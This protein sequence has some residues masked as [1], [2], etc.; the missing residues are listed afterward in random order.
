MR[1]CNAPWLKDQSFNSWIPAPPPLIPQRSPTAS[2]LFRELGGLHIMVQVRACC[3]L[4]VRIVGLG[5]IT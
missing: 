1:Y 3:C 5:E 2:S 4:A